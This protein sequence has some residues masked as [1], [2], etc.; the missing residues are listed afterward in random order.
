MIQPYCFIVLQSCLVILCNIFLN[1]I[2]VEP[3]SVVG[4]QEFAHV[5][6]LVATGI[7]T[8]GKYVIVLTQNI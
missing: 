5:L 8:L 6:L 2:I 4:N 3:E 1:L 7:N